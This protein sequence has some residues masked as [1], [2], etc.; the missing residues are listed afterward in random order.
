VFVTQEAYI[1]NISPATASSS[2]SKKKLTI[3]DWIAFDLEW[4]IE[5][6]SSENNVVS[7]SRQTLYNADF[8]SGTSVPPAHDYHKILTF[9]YEN[10]QGNNGT[11]DISDFVDCPNPEKAFLEAIKAKLLQYKYCFAWGSKAIKYNN[12][13]KVIW[14]ALT[15]TLL[16]LM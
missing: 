8:T 4:E 16:C 5:P 11:F 6:K 7:C 12:K 15:A 14:R 10:S 9:G 2:T 1:L 3:D 13:N